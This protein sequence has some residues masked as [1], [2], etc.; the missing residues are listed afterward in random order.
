MIHRSTTEE[1][2]LINMVAI[3]AVRASN[4]KISS[5]FPPSPTALFVGAT[6]GIGQA[7][8]EAFAA[9]TQS[10]IIY[11]VGRSK[12][13]GESI[14][15]DVKQ[16]INPRGTYEFIQADCALIAEVDRVCDYVKEKVG[17]K[18]DFLCLSCGYL[19]FDG[20]NGMFALILFIYLGLPRHGHQFSSSPFKSMARL[21]P[22]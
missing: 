12:A 16:R 3:S 14:A 6:S 20:R 9:N 11:F 19:S 18:L 7:T 10:P 22:R 5:T 17:A 4:A 15:R 1:F 8:L 13:A 2:Q 21:Q